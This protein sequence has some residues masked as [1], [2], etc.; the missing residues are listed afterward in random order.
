MKRIALVAAAAASLAMPALAADGD[1]ESDA[2]KAAHAA[3]ADRAEPFAMPPTLPDAASDRAKDVSF[4]QQGAR[5]KAD[6][7]RKA[8][9][10]AGKQGKDSAKDA[11]VDAANRAAQGAATSA[12]GAANADSHAAAGQARAAAVRDGTPSP[13]P[14]KGH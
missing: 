7:A 9:D 2:V 10:E 5:K 8:Q 14:G 12:A 1:M 6:A 13:P 3:L 11:D 4:G